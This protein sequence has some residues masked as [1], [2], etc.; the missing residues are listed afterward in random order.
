MRRQSERRQI[1]AIKGPAPDATRSDISQK[2]QVSRGA[3]CGLIGREIVRLGGFSTR[4][5]AWRA[6]LR[7]RSG[8]PLFVLLNPLIDFRGCNLAF[9]Q[10]RVQ[11]RRRGF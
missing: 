7:L 3:I 8:W 2:F 11:G 6:G 10:V 4:D 5:E 9:W 1:A